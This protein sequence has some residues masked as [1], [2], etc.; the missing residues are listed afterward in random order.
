MVPTVVTSSK[1]MTWMEIS[2]SRTESYGRLIMEY[3]LQY[4]ID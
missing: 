1:I 4:P 2:I 3:S